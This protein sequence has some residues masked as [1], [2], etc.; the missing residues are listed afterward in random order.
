VL[1]LEHPEKQT[2]PKK[3]NTIPTFV[4]KGKGKKKRKE[5]PLQ[6]SIEEENSTQN[7][8]ENYIVISAC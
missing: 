7:E 4:R 2:T 8:L 5:N 6:L 1:V 3:A